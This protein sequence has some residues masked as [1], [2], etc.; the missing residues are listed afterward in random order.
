MND[1]MDKINRDLRNV[2]CEGFC[3]EV[4]SE[5]MIVRRLNAWQFNVTIEHDGREIT[6]YA[7]DSQKVCDWAKQM[8]SDNEES[9]YYPYY[10]TVAA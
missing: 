1:T 8:I 2:K 6:Y 10:S 3:L 5:E 4:G 7:V 9:S